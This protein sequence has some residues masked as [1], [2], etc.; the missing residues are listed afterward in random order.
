MSRLIELLVQTVCLNDLDRS[1]DRPEYCWTV[2]LDWSNWTVRTVWTDSPAG[3]LGALEF[4]DKRAQTLLEKFTVKKLKTF[5]DSIGIE[6]GLS[7]KKKTGLVD[8]LAKIPNILERF[9]GFEME[10]ELPL[11]ES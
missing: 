4:P 6:C 10:R 11:V 2:Q 7:M 3:P 9:D 5:C 1:L 8:A